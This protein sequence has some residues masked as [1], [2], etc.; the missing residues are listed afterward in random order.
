MKE[1]IRALKRADLLLFME[2][3]VNHMYHDPYAPAGREY[4]PEKE[5]GGADTVEFLCDELHR[6]GLRP[7]PIVD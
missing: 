1:K 7:E 6:L 4:D 5:V 3:L 2:R